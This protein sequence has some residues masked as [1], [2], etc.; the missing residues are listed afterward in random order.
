[1]TRHYVLEVPLNVVI[2]PRKTT[3][4][5]RKRPMNTLKFT[6]ADLKASTDLKTNQTTGSGS[7][8]PNM[9]SALNI[10]MSERGIKD[11]DVIGSTLRGGYNR[12]VKAHVATLRAQGRPSAYVSNRK[13]LLNQWRRELLEA[14]RVAAIGLGRE[15]PF[16]TA[17]KEVFSHGATIKGTCRTC[18]VPLATLRRWFA[19]GI[20]NCKSIVWVPVLERHFGLTLGTL[21]DLLP[22]T[23]RTRDLQAVAASPIAYRQR[24]KQQTTEHYAIRN[25]SETL[26][27]EWGAFVAH[28]TAIGIGGRGNLSRSKN[29]RWSTTRAP[30][31]RKTA[32]LWYAFRGDEYVATASMRWQHVSQY[33][34]WLTLSEEEGGKGF[35]ESSAMTLA[36]FARDD[37]IF[38]YQEWRIARSGGITHAG[39][40]GF[41][42]FAAG[43]CHPTTGYLTHSWDR[44]SEKGRARSQDEWHQDCGFAFDLARKNQDE[45]SEVRKPSR[46][47]FEPIQAT[48]SLPNPLDGVADAVL[49][50]DAERHTTGG[51]EEAVW[52]RDRL[53]LKLLASN[54]LRDK[55]TRMLIYRD[56]NKGHLRQVD[57]KWR[58]AIPK[59]EF[60]N[61]RG[62]AKT[63][64]YDMPV[65]QEVWHDIEQYLRV[66]RPVLAAPGNQYVFVSTKGGNGP[67]DSLRRRFEFLTRRYLAGCPGVGPQAMRHIVATSILKQSPNDWAAAAWALHDKEETVKMH[68][69][70]LR[71]DDA[72]RWFDA[73]MN[74]P[75]SRM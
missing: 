63:R 18:A 75:F 45:L 62:A 12:C 26:R 37:L 58:I 36:H 6:F 15:S 35:D 56:D 11:N 23:L 52:A 22:R 47:S 28:K 50:L 39:V 7:S 69:A 61:A 10:F 65:R 59:D 71:S 46:N 57:G 51:Q 30:V 4:R 55:N 53:L 54:P 20:P 68:Y 19:G 27:A 60:K 9:L 44:F 33:L 24:L 67:M 64:N 29:G 74:G 31:K 41:L 14:D 70:H 25:P 72:Q 5:A 42:S 13:A 66:Y 34:G 8:R 17:L 21:Q 38:S 3:R 32:S 49:R 73:A 48:L 40:L 1:M 16:Q 43:L 2:Y